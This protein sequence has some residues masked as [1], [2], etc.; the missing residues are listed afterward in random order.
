MK[1]F[2][3]FGLLLFLAGTVYW[4]LRFVRRGAG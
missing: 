3:G 2:G 4:L 1:A